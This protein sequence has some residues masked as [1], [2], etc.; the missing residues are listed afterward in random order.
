[1]YSEITVLVRIILY[2]IGGA[3]VGA[4][5]ITASMAATLVSPPIVA[6]VSGVVMFIGAFVWYRYSEAREALLE[7]KNR[8]QPDVSS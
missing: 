4:G 3:L 1:M 7:W 8:K 5:L 6:L 2:A